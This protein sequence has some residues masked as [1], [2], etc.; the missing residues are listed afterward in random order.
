MA[1]LEQQFAG[2]SNAGALSASFSGTLNVLMW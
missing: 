2:R 1:A